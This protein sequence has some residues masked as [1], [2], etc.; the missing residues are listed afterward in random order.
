MGR[1]LGRIINF[2][3]LGR[4]SRVYASDAQAPGLRRLRP[5]QQQP[6]LSSCASA[7]DP[8]IFLLSL[9]LVIT[10]MGFQA[11]TAWRARERGPSSAA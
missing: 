8:S 6:V 11:A 5:S 2:G 1:S 9:A 7:S 10:E 4:P 3:G